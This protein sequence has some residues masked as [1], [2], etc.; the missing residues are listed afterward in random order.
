MA[1]YTRN[2]DW[3]NVGSLSDI[4]KKY[5]SGYVPYTRYTEGIGSWGEGSRY[6]GLADWFRENLAQEDIS[7]DVKEFIAGLDDS[8]L[9]ALLIDAGEKDGSQFLWEKQKTIDV[10]SILNGLN[11]I[12]EL[13]DLP[14]LY[15]TEDIRKNISDQIDAENAKVLDLY[16]KDLARQT[17]LYTSQMEGLNDNYNTFARNILSNDYQKNA[18]LLGTLSTS[19]DKSRRNALEA[20]ANAGLRIAGNINTVMSA[21]NKQTATSLETA[22]NLAQQLINQQNAARGIQGA[23]ANTMSNDT[24]RRANLYSGG[25]ERKQA[26]TTGAVQEAQTDYENKMDRYNDATAYL[27]NETPF[28]DAYL[29]YKKG[30]ANTY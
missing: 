30:K 4:E 2:H 5:G 28:A 20:G 15:N 11:K 10:D 6:H 27:R 23:F 17:N 25:V 7:D 9:E 19:L 3:Y 12:S 13:P 14:T 18:S 8:T 24:N 29:N 1:K 21:Q 22:N 16:D 26:A